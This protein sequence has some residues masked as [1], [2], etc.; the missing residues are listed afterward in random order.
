MS[1]CTQTMAGSKTR[2]FQPTRPEGRHGLRQETILFT[3]LPQ[4]SGP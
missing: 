1:A 3:P 4:T 2:N